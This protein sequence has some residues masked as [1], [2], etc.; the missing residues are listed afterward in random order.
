MGKLFT[1]FVLSAKKDK[2][3]AISNIVLTYETFFLQIIRSLVFISTTLLLS[4]H[5]IGCAS[6]SGPQHSENII[7][8]P[9]N[10]ELGEELILL[11]DPLKSSDIASLIDT[12]GRA[13]VFMVDSKNQ[14]NHIQIL[15][16]NSIM[17]EILGIVESKGI[18]KDKLF[19][20]TV[21]HPAGNL[22]VLANNKQYIR[23]SSDSKWQERGENRC[24]KFISA[25]DDLFCAF[26]TKGEDISS[27]K[28]KDYSGVV[29]MVLPI[30]WWKNVEVSKLVLA[31]ETDD[32]W[33][34][35]AVLDHDT[36]WDA[37]NGFM[38]DYDEHGKFHLLYYISRGGAWYWVAG[39]PGGGGV[40]G[41]ASHN[42]DLRYARVDISQLSP[43]NEQDNDDNENDLIQKSRSKEWLPIN[44][45]AITPFPKQIY[46]SSQSPK[47][48]AVNKVTGDVEGLMSTEYITLHEGQS[49]PSHE[50]MTQ[51]DFL[52]ERYDF[53]YAKVS[54]LKKD[55]KGNSHALSIGMKTGFWKGH[56]CMTYLE[57]D[58][59]KWSAPIY[60]G[61]R[62]D[63][64]SDSSLTLDRSGRL[65]ASWIN[66][67]GKLT[68]RW[69]MLG[70][71]EFQ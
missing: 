69:I 11:T 17:H 57:K 36:D 63:A 24:E 53:D 71:G 23:S 64:W 41:G 55:Y 70:S 49:S 61:N 20:D 6:V 5:L 25:G 47:V 44:G 39:G 22:R 51:K 18:F 7:R 56:F 9:P 68:G 48:F 42:P 4:T 27:P 35:K 54:I 8:Q 52:S 33:V 3:G 50:T 29:I 34:I 65:F 32:G 38:A 14:L 30:F 19:I 10:V 40:I 45:T 62:E 60:L 28:R 15:A 13:H 66:A 1:E 2:S 12:D 26:V 16:D 58:G 21:E 31:K 46:D 37:N 43:V 59:D 67:E